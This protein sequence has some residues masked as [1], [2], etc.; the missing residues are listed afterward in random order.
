[1][2]WSLRAINSGKTVAVRNQ[3]LSWRFRLVLRIVVQSQVRFEL[4][5]GFGTQLSEGRQSAFIGPLVR[6]GCEGDINLQNTGIY[7]ICSW[8]HSI[9]CQPNGC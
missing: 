5:Q 4:V 3:V 8:I 9:S 7:D 6:Q 1:M 2:L